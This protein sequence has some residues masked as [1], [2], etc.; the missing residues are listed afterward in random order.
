[1]QKKQSSKSARTTPVCLTPPAM[2][3]RNQCRF[4]FAILMAVIFSFTV[5]A[6]HA[7][8]SP[9]DA[10]VKIEPHLAAVIAPGG[11]S[12]ALIVLS[13]QA[14]LSGAQSLSTKLEKGQYVYARLREVAERT[15]APLRKRLDEMGIPYESFYSVNMIK[16]NAS[17]DQ[18]YELAGRDEVVRLEPNP[19]VKSAILP[20]SGT[21][22]VLVA[23]NS[24]STPSTGITWNVAKVNAPQ[25]WSMGFKG[26]GIVVAS[27]DTGVMW[28]HPSLKSHYRGW[29]GSTANYNYNWYDA[30]STHSATPV[31]ANGHGTFTASEMV[32]DDGLGNRIGIAPGAKWI[33][34]RNMDQS[35]VGSPAT[36]T[37]CFDF[38]L[39]PYPIG[40]PQL[41][42][43]AMAPDII[44]NSWACPPSEGCSV[45]TLLSI[46]NAVRAAGIFPVVAA[47]NSGPHCST[48]NQPPAIYASSVTVGATD[49]YNYIAAFSSRGPVTVDGSG[50]LKPELVAPGQYITGAIPYS[51]WY[52]N[53]WSGTSMAAPEVAGAVAL[54]WQAKPRLI[55]NISTTES[56]LKQ[57]ATR[58][59]STQSCSG[60][61]G[62]SIPNAVFGYGLLNILRAVQAP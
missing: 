38:L 20:S 62:T 9:S 17:R 24:L 11:N 42:S 52:Q 44:N 48:V 36:Y 60:Y 21:L 35:G 19:R 27:A 31:D 40:H 32:G 47:G 55:G 37:A 56:Y 10:L 16:V 7:Q 18:L 49:S 57:N 29:N 33:A 28:N 8:A 50:R 61:P 41:A 34:C 3:A 53:Y 22:S 54:L 25:V 4:L 12:D 45:N 13:E 43:P 14:D 46:V 59:T 5:P 26:Q 30:T 23:L 51:P 2:T 6:L 58:L 1:M 39:A 15:Q